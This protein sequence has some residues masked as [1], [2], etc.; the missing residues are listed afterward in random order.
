MGN[1]YLT[2]RYGITAIVFYSLLIS[3]C[4]VGR[5]IP[6]NEH[7]LKKNKVKVYG[8]IT[9]GEVSAQILHRANKRVLF[10]KVPIYL[11]SYSL[12]TKHKN[13]N[14]SDSIKWRNKMR[15]KLGEPP[16]LLDTGSVNLS[17]NNI[18][19]YL[20]NIGYFDAQVIPKIKYRKKKAVVKYNV[21]PN[22]V[23]K[24][25]S[26][27]IEA[28]D[29]SFKPLV[30]SL[31]AKSNYFRLWWPLNLNKL[32][33]ARRFMAN[34]M[35]NMG[36]FTVTAESFRYE[37]DTVKSKKE[38]AVTIILENDLQGK[39]HKIYRFSDV[40]INLETSGVYKRSKNPEFAYINNK[41]I[42]L[43]Q[44]PVN[45]NTLAKLVYIDSGKIYTQQSIERSYQALVQMGLFSLV[46]I[47]LTVDTATHTIATLI[48]LKTTP[49]MA[50]SVEPQGLYS[51]QGT[52]GTNFQTS[53]Q[54]SFGVAGIV[55]FTD[56]NL[57]RN[58]ENLRI[59]SITSYEAIIRKDN[60]NNLLFGLQQGF[61]ASLSLP[62]FK[63]LSS[64]RPGNQTSQR[65][66]VIS[67]SYQFENNQYFLRSAIPASLTF[68]YV[69]PRFSWY[70][71]P[72][73]LSFNRNEM[74]TEYAASLPKADSF[75]ISRV[76]TN[77]FLTAAKIG[78][79]YSNRANKPGETYLFT[80]AGF[81]T[82]GNVHHAIRRLEKSFSSD[83]VY[84]LFGL[85]YF[86]YAKI[87]AEVRLRQN[88][89]ELNSIAFRIN[90]GIAIPYGNSDYIPYDK[91]Y[92]IGGSNSL[93]AWRPRRLGPG[94]TPDTSNFIIDRSGEFLIETNLEYRFT[95][96]KQLLE[97]ALF[98]DMGN[99][100]NLN[101]QDQTIPPASILKG[102]K[103]F[104]DLALNTGIGFRFDFT[105]FLFRVDWGIPLRDP[106][107]SLG[108]RWLITQKNLED[109]F[110]FIKKETALAFGIGY[111]F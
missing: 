92:F 2:F 27:Y 3:S 72:T 100:W 59:S 93:R 25:N 55:S 89:D 53:N 41:S 66:T 85:Q 16:V 58:G 54:R 11:W 56:K 39:P 81:E 26:I 110:G 111:P 62:H 74:S 19:N 71:T 43:N 105:F 35:R 1:K 6:K 28:E 33:V 102:S 64:L 40:Q 96:I 78:F 49:R 67:L 84:S 97:S 94:S 104:D 61:N 79:V 99:I 47:R 51:P 30:D 5:T 48:D 76:F 23:Y 91:R 7:L 46:D 82:S 109:P 75:F 88:L 50:I 63:I 12:G 24:I 77:Q 10:D 70:Y 90:S 45:P 42:K 106:S 52:S 9:G 14:I 22:T 17:A 68:Q 18:R 108:N 4:G 107:K 15:N 29:S 31:A 32:D 36:Y 86:Q 87:D 103:F 21:F 83:S 80:R 98:M 101:R 44:Y 57:S 38:G 8:K 20:F 60:K 69:K 73:E 13:P 37:I 95:L 65:N 34:E